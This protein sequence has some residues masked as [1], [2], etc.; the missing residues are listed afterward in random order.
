MGKELIKVVDGMW[1]NNSKTSNAE[2]LGK[3]IEVCRKICF[4][5]QGI[6][7]H[8]VPMTQTTSDKLY[9]DIC[10]PK[11]TY[12]LKVVDINDVQANNLEAFNLMAKMQ[13]GLP[14]QCSNTGSAC[15]H[16]G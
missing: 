3:R 15:S 5:G 1:L 8:R 11:L 13:Q 4:A 7:S 10:I 9:K 12:G 6:G 16:N 2:W 14:R